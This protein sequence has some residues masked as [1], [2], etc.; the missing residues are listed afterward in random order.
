MEITK[1][2][3]LEKGKECYTRQELADILN[4]S[5]SSIK[6]LFVKYELSAKDVLKQKQKKY[7]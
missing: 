6:R 4:T 1:E 5:L 2:T 3:I 7:C